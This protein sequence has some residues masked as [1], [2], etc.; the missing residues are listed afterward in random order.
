MIPLSEVV[1]AGREDS[2]WLELAVA[3]VEDAPGTDGAGIERLTE[4]S[5]IG[6]GM[7]SEIPLSDVVASPLCVEL[8]G[9][10]VGD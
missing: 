6:R 9:T 7:E 10:G 8:S 2:P 3:V 4:G 5:V 1:P